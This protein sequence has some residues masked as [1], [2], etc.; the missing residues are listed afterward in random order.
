[1]TVRYMLRPSLTDINLKIKIF[2]TW[3]FLMPV[4]RLLPLRNKVVFANFF[5]NPPGDDPKYIMEELLSQQ[6]NLTYVWPVKD[7][8]FV[9]PDGLVKVRYNSLRY[10]YHVCTAKVWIFNIRNI[11]HPPKRKGQLYIQTWHATTGL[12]TAE[13]A[14]ED[15]L[16]PEYVRIVKRDSADTDLMYTNNDSAYYQYTHLFW[17]SGPVYK[18]DVPRTGALMNRIDE[19]RKIVH[20]FFQIRNKKIALYAPTYRDSLETH[21]YIW[22]Y[23]RVLKSLNDRFGHDYVLLIRLHPNVAHLDDC[24]A[25]GNTVIN[26]SRYPDM[27]ELLATADVLINDFSST[28]FEF[29]FLNKPVFLYAP[30]FDQ[31]IKQERNLFYS[32]EELPFRINKDLDSLCADIQSFNE[33]AYLNKCRAF[34]KRIGM[35]DN[36][37]GSKILA[38]YVIQFI[39]TGNYEFAQEDSPSS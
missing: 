17:Y 10:Y 4:F 33:S 27:Q 36:G 14:I 2:I 6:P 7:L 8:N 15:V 13:A 29:A 12:K 19:K 34:Y 1:M 23:D 9:I 32:F 3:H 5:G 39:E 38:D 31:F 22:D 16:D 30:D 20:D 25:Y 35:E 24:I 28:M 11:S 18:T 21:L 26:A 37:M